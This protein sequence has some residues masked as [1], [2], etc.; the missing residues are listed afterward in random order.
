VVKGYYT[1]VVT[2]MAEEWLKRAAR[3]Q[4]LVPHD[5]PQGAAQLLFPRAEV[6]ARFDHVRIPYPET[7]FMLDDKP[8]WIKERLYTW[9]GIY[10]PLFDWRK[11]F[12]DDS[13]RGRQGLRG[14]DPRLLGHAP[15]RGRQRRPPLRAAEKQRGELDNTIIV[16]MSDNGI[17]NGEHGMVDKRTMHEPSIRI[18][19]VVRYPGLTPPD[20][21]KGRRAAGAHVDMAPSLLELCGAP[22]LPEHPR[23]ILGEAGAGRA[24]LLA[25]ILALPLQLREAVP[26]HAQRPQRAH[27][28]L[29]IHPLPARRRRPRPPPGRALQHRV[30]PRRAPQPHLADAIGNA[31]F[32]SGGPQTPEDVETNNEDEE[33]A[34][35]GEAKVEE[36]K[37]ET[38]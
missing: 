18:V 26:L 28:H 1:T 37:T 16:F 33:D 32:L 36:A 15:L 19:Q 25:Q 23:Q 35:A 13:P 6:R 17:L 3:R 20:Q 29:E 24:T 5:R 38:P 10:G 8:A 11:K 2:D 22:P 7:A 31:V 30:R 4:A 12:P 14:H 9:H 21:P 27:R 34:A